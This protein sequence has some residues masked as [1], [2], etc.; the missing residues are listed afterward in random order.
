MAAG[1]ARSKRAEGPCCLLHCAVQPAALWIE[2][3]GPQ[4]ACAPALQGLTHCLGPLPSPPCQPPCRRAYSALSWGS[5]CDELRRGLDLAKKV[6]QALVNGE[7]AM[8]RSVEHVLRQRQLHLAPSHT[9]ELCSMHTPVCL[10]SCQS[11]WYRGCASRGS[12]R[13]RLGTASEP[14]PTSTCAH[15]PAD[16]GAVIQQKHYHNFKQFRIFD[17]SDHKMNSQHLIVG[18]RQPAGW[19]PARA[20]ACVR[21][22][23]APKSRNSCPPAGRHGSRLLC[24]DPHF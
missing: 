20:R 18:A 17:L 14:G 8:G 23:G 6:Q 9:A 7:R 2:R 21:T 15:T 16:G 24:R 11:A 1:L 3:F 19:P 10:S 4:P 12:I 5:D 13:P 22:C